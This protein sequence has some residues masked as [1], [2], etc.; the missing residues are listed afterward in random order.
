MVWP[1]IAKRAGSDQGSYALRV[2]VTV[3][4]TGRDTSA[5]LV[6]ARADR[7]AQPQGAERDPGTDDRQDQCIFGMRSALGIP[8]QFPEAVHLDRLF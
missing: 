5:R 2:S 3:G 8:E 7:S 6:H 4:S 1:D